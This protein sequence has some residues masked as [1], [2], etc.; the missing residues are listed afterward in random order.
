[1]HPMFRYAALF[2]LWA[3]PTHA[4]GLKATSFTL[5]N[6]LEV[7]VVEYHRAPVVT[8]MIWLRAGAA[9]EPKGVSGV[10]HYLEHMMFKGTKTVPDGEYTKRIERL[11]G[12][13]NAFTGADFTAYYVTIAKEHLPVVMALE[14]DRMQHLAPQ[15]FAS[16][17]EVIIEE[18]RSRI[19][20]Q[21]QAIL[22]EKMGARLFAGHPYGIPII[23]WKEEMAKL[24][25]EDVMRYYR[26]HYHPSAAV[27]VLVGDIDPQVARTLAEKHYASWPKGD[28]PT[29][30]WPAFTPPKQAERI[31]FAHAEVRQ[32]VWGRDYPAPSLVHGDTTQAFPLMLLADMLGDGRS[33]WLYKRL[34]VE[35]K[36]AVDASVSYSGFALGPTALGV[37]LVPAK[38]VTLEALETAYEEELAAFVNTDIAPRDLQ[39]VKNNLKASAVY[40]RDGLQGQ[41]FTLGHL[42]ML[43]FDEDFLD[44]WSKNIE[45]VTAAEVVSVARAVMRPERSVTGELLPS[46]DG[47][48]P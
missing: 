47:A 9:D 10:A 5:D 19:D 30:Q 6:G 18:R 21:P 35:R 3:L 12:E 36:L 16:E 31:R 38:G 23:G 44:Q 48:T 25:K 17:R 8:H 11:G 46:T 41:A 32:P 14:A 34:V 39:R 37:T 26:T 15:G 20:N 1:M 7:R 43:G 42:L 45:A 29:R 28:A 40:L 13:H 2:V 27:L 22:A 24:S 33:S 4:E